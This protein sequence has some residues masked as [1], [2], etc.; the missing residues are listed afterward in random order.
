MKNWLLIPVGM[1]L[2]TLAAA[3]TPQQIIQKYYPRYLQSH[4]CL[5]G[6]DQDGQTAYCM[7][8]KA[9]EI[10]ETAQGKFMYVLMAGDYI[11]LAYPDEEGAHA[12]SGL[13]GMFVL[14]QAGANGWTLAAALPKVLIGSWGKAP[15]KWTFHEFGQDRWGFLTESGYTN[16][17]VTETR[18]TMLHH[19]GNRRVKESSIAS[20]SDNSGYYG[21]CI[22]QP[23][24]RERVECERNSTSLEAGIK[25]DR[26]SA[27]SSGF[28]PLILTVSGH[29]GIKKYR[30][31]AYRI[32]FNARQQKYIA[33]KNYP[34]F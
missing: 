31:Q 1:S 21:D 11:D 28:Y 4:Q 17:G 5:I 27:A 6:T 15:E 16:Q 8:Q 18:Y 29:R 34:L 25:I 3:Q 30:N 19:D 7:K 26:K 12:A 14:K 24:A 32:P 22:D 33:P 13:A 10:R 9:R 20:G 2:C 23:S